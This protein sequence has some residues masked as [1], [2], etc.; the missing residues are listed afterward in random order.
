MFDI[1]TDC[2]YQNETE[3]AQKREALKWNIR[4]ADGR[5]QKAEIKP[6]LINKRLRIPSILFSV[7][8]LTHTNCTFCLVQNGPELSQK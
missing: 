3:L 2:K 6:F 1:F 8:F 4:P 7:V 5:G